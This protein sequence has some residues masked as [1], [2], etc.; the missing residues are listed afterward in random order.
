MGLSESDNL[1]DEP[2]NS[3]ET[4]SDIE[5]ETVVE[6]ANETPTEEGA[7]GDDGDGK[8]GDEPPQ[9]PI[10]DGDIEPISIEEEMKT[11][12]LDYAMSVIVSRALP[13]VRDGLKPVHR[14]ILFS[15]NENGYDYNKP[16]RKSADLRYGLL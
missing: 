13:D 14:R 2:E 1:T 8:G 7:G 5:A 10:D 4:E 9:P 16:Y 3:G 11:S 6:E 15:M 12:Y